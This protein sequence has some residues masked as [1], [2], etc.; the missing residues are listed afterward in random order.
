MP[1]IDTIVKSLNVRTVYRI[2]HSEQQNWNRIGKYY[3]QCLDARFGQTYFMCLCTTIKGIN[4][5]LVFQFDPFYNKAV[6]D[7]AECRKIM[8]DTIPENAMLFGNHQ[9][10][11]RNQPLFSRHL[12]KVMIFTL[13]IG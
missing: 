1:N 13:S 6:T 8:S 7:W 10:M 9:I 12:R 2:I 11:V 3:L 5:N 4:N